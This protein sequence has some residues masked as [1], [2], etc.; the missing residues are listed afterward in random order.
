MSEKDRSKSESLRAY[1]K[2]FF[3]WAVMVGV[4]LLIVIEVYGRLQ[5][6]RYK[7]LFEGLLAIGQVALNYREEH[8]AFPESVEELRA[9]AGENSVTEKGALPREDPWGEEYRYFRVSDDRAAIVSGGGNRKI[10]TGLDDLS[11]ESTDAAME[12]IFFIGEKDDWI[13]LV[14]PWWEAEEE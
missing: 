1:M 14:E 6:R 7:E 11:A 10:E 8:G 12:E 3:M 9:F 2:M 5:G 13:Y 4:M